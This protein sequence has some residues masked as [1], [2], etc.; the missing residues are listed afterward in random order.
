MINSGLS[1]AAGRIAK[2]ILVDN[3]V[4]GMIR[5]MDWPRIF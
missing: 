3:V 4:A 2:T 5:R 1:P